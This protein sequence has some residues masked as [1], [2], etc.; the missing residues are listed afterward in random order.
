MN[1]NHLTLLCLVDGLPSFRAFEIEVSAAR[2]IAHL[3]NLIKTK[4]TPAFDDIT[5]DQ[6][7][8]WRVSVAI[9][10]DDDGKTPILLDNLPVKKELRVTS[11]LFMVFDADLPEDTIHVI[12]QR[13]PPAA[14]REREDDAGL[15][16]ESK[17]HRPYTLMDAIEKADLTEK[18]VVDN[19]FDLTCLDNKERVSLLD[20]LGEEIGR[21][22]TFDSLSST[23]RELQGADMESMDKLSTP[24]GTKL[25]V[26]NT[27]ELYVRK[28]YKDLH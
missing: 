5:V 7:T 17:R 28:A 15:S 3:K 11:K 1:D 8:L 24:H 2:T 27:K 13:P 18:A 16:S 6:L 20:F 25:P 10:D 19:R 14:K 12:V 4:Q 26:V 21:S 9:T 22:D 23:A